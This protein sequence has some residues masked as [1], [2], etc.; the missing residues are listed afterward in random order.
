MELNQKNK[1]NTI[2]ICPDIH[3]RS[4]YKPILNVKD[5]PI[6]FMGDYMDPYWY[7]GTTDERGIENF[8]EIIDFAKNN[9]NVTLL[10]GNHCESWIWS[11]MNFERTSYEHYDELH[12]LY[13]DNIELF[14][15]CKKIDNVLFTHAGVSDGWVN[16][17]NNSFYWNE[18]G[19]ELENPSFIITEDNIDSYINSEFKKELKHEKARHHLWD[20]YLDSPIFDIGYAR[21]GNAS[22]GGPFWDDFR[23]EYWDPKGWNTIQ[24]FSHTQREVTGS[25]GINGNGYCIDSRAIFEYDVESETISKANLL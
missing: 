7:E 3:C 24:I 23:D 16:S 22:Y 9:A 10:V 25:I 18:N 13:R 2:L 19:E 5:T 8:K 4:F 1:A 15:A 11:P 12:K 20:S 14:H 6:I 21:G 17:I